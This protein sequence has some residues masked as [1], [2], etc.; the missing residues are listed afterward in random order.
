MA[1]VSY[2][3]KFMGFIGFQERHESPGC[4]G[5]IKEETRKGAEN[6]ISGFVVKK[7]RGTLEGI[8]E[9]KRR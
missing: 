1:S 4:C 5:R 3:K 6:N 2:E 8:A 9:E 7:E